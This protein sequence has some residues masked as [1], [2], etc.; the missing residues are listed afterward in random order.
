MLFKVVYKKSC[1][2]QDLITSGTLQT[3]IKSKV[4]SIKR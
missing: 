2:E 3:N 4:Y 1:E